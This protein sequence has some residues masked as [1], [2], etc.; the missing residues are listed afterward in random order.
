MMITVEQAAKRSN[1][2]PK[3]IRTWISEGLRAEKP[4]GGG[5]WFIDDRHLWK[6]LRERRKYTK[7]SENVTSDQTGGGQETP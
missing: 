6:W 4:P 3:T 5:M 7:G 2:S 1:R